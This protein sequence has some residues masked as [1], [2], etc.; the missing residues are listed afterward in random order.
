MAPHP[1]H[2]A[3]NLSS[4]LYL[5]NP[6]QRRR[7]RSRLVHLQPVHPQLPH[8]EDPHLISRHRDDVIEQQPAH[9]VLRRLVQELMDRILDKRHLEFMLRLWDTRRVCVLQ[10]GWY[11]YRQ[12]QDLVMHGLFQVLAEHFGAQHVHR[13][14]EKV[15]G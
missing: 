3:A 14:A 10:I 2:P 7:R 13:L 4:P 8:Y 9:A 12:T 1:R 15:I 11:W 5:R 6:C